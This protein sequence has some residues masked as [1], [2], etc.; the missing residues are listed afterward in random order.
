MTKKSE[1]PEHT[2]TDVD[3][4][5]YATPETPPT[6]T[7]SLP[8]PVLERRTAYLVN[9]R[10]IIDTSLDEGEK[11]HRERCI[12]RGVSPSHF[13]FTGTNA[14]KTRHDV[15]VVFEEQK[16]SNYWEALLCSCPTG[17]HEG[18]PCWHKGAVRAFL[19]DN[20]HIRHANT[21]LALPLI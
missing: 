20:Q 16:A 6:S 13:I 9:R 14:A 7:E 19:A 18:D 17:R 5:V 12:R 21:L 4:V 10:R 8:N 1:Q 3:P 2:P 15:H 11:L